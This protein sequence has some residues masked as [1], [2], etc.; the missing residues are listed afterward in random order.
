MLEA[1]AR[2]FWK[3]YAYILGQI[4]HLGCFIQTLFYGLIIRGG[5]FTTAELTSVETFESGKLGI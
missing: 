4:L 3:Q 1:R 2:S 5:A